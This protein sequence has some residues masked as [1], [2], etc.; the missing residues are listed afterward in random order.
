MLNRRIL[1]V[2]LIGAAA[3]A[4]SPLAASAQ[5]VLGQGNFVGKS[6]HKTSGGVTI[7]KTGQSIEVRL[8]ADF[9]LDSA[10]D[11]WV[12]F[13]KSGKYDS[14]SE[15]AILKSKTGAQVYKIPGIIDTSKY[16]ELYIW[17]RKFGVPLGVAKLK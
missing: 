4:M 5:E 6:G 11:P 15:I 17:C 9:K 12:G 7:V 2:S 14:A 10:P 8:G 13:G 3:V 1:I 16:N